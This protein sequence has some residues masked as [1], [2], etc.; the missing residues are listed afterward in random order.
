MTLLLSEF[1]H[2]SNLRCNK[3]ELQFRKSIDDVEMIDG[4]ERQSRIGS[5]PAHPVGVVRTRVSGVLT[6]TSRLRR[7]SRAL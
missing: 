4:A 5:G 3:R 6:T 1:D 2:L 7:E